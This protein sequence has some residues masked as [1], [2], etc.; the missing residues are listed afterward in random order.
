LNVYIVGSNNTVAAIKNARM[1]CLG[2]LQCDIDTFYVCED[3]R[4]C[5]QIVKV[6]HLYRIEE[7][8]E[9]LAS[10]DPEVRKQA[11]L[12]FK[13]L[14]DTSWRQIMK[15]FAVHPGY[16][17]SSPTCSKHY[18][19]ASELMR[20]FRVPKS[21]CIIWDDEDPG[22]YLGL[23]YE[24]YLHLYP[25]P[26]GNYRMTCL[27]NFDDRLCKVDETYICCDASACLQIVEIRD[28]QNIEELTEFLV[29]EDPEVRKQALLQFEKL[30][31]TPSNPALGGL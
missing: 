17:F 27:G 19:S 28:T 4:A 25:D 23:K 10:E 13:K 2:K 26:R 18:I 11:L 8:T 6:C 16:V 3:A 31:N 5:L 15:R 1:P 24:D 7:L 9:Y 29:S 14:K 20:L 22:A 30:R 12:Q 21:L